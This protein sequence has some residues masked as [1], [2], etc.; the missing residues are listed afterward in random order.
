MMLLNEHIW[1]KLDEEDYCTAAQLYLL[2]QHIFTG[3]TLENADISQRLPIILRIKYTTESLKSRI[4]KN[5]KQKMQEVVLTSNV[6]V[7][8]N[9]INFFVPFLYI[10]G[11]SKQFKCF[12][13]IRKFYKYRCITNLY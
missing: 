13:T 5:V 4:L 8:S 1:L 10:P 3:L 2:V 7:Y 12:N 6:S 11:S 9:T